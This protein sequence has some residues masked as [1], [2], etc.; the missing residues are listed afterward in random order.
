MIKKCKPHFK[1]GDVKKH[2]TPNQASFALG[3]KKCKDKFEN[4]AVEWLKNNIRVVHIGN[5]HYVVA[6]NEFTTEYDFILGFK[7]MLNK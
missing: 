3:Y 5:K 2:I 1:I 7:Q 6:S 4:K